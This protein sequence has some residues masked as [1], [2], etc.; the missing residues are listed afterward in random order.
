MQEVI[1]IILILIIFASD[2]PLADG[3][4]YWEKLNN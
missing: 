2:L 1:M 4:V 3:S